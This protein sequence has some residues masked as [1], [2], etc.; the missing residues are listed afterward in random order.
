MK[1]G[2]LITARLKSSRLKL[3]LLKQLNGYSVIERVINRAK[4]VIECDDIILC[5]STVNQDLPL[6]RIAKENNIYYFTG[7]PDDVLK[8]LNE[9]AI[10]F[11]FD[12]IVGITADNPLFSIRYA[13]LIVDRIRNDP[14]IDY[15]FSSGNPIG[16]NMYAIKSKALQVVCEIKEEVDTEIWGRLINRPEIFNVVEVETEDKDIVSI[17]RITL[18]EPDDYEFFHEIHNKFDKDY[19]IE[20]MDLKKVLTQH[21]DIKDINSGVQQLDLEKESIRRINDFYEDNHDFINS[22]KDGIY[23]Y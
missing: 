1:I 12:Y 18:D 11:G 20:E 9:A 14:S 23:K 13:N 21:P 4:Q 2:F 19:I 17:P 6:V 10:L 22:V 3:K 15:I 8:R 5:T 16:M 7:D